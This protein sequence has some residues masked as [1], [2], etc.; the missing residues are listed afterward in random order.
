MSQTEIDLDSVPD[1]THFCPETYFDWPCFYK[2]DES[3]NWVGKL[4]S[5]DAWDGCV[6]VDQ[7]TLEHMVT[8]PQE[9]E[10]Q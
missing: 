1:A 6:A 2:K 3:G 5:D 7:H 8:R 10:K 9:G 4:N